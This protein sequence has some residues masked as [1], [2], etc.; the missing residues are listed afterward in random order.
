MASNSEIPGDITSLLAALE[1]GDTAALDD[2][3]E[4]AYQELRGIAASY[5]R[6]GTLQN[7]L[8]PL[9]WSTSF[10]CA[11]RGSVA[12]NFRTVATSTRSRP[13]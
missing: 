12:L 11:W 8:Q 9:N 4:V 2:L 6:Q 1:R 5:L 7:T 13:C 10:I 3:V